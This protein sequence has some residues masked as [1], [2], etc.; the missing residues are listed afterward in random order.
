MAG[1]RA[2]QTGWGAGRG[3]WLRPR[4]TMT[5]STVQPVPSDTAIPQQDLGSE[6]LWGV[7][8]LGSQHGQDWAPAF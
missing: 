1:W 4:L 6:G 2:E 7:P 3:E 5:A 8:T